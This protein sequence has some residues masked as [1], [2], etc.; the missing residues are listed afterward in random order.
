L[1]SLG[2]RTGLIVASLIPMSMVCGILVMSFLDISI[3]QISLAAL[4]IALG[5]LVDNGI[6]MSENIMVQMEKGKKAIDAAVDSANELKVPL[7]VSSLTT[8]AAF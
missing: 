1:F 7:L 2:L 3:D 5:M 6:V 8:G 4:I